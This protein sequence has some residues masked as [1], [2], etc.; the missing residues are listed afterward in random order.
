MGNYVTGLETS[1]DVLGG[2]E[3]VAVT[4]PGRMASCHVCALLLWSL[5][6]PSLSV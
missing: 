1:G 5:E 3:S 6:D 2:T 4:V